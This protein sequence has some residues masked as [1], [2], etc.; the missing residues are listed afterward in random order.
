MIWAAGWAVAAALAAAHLLRRG[1]WQVWQGHVPVHT[2]LSLSRGMELCVRAW[3][4]GAP[5]GEVRLVARMGGT[6]IASIGY[7]DYAAMPA[8]APPRAH[9]AGRRARREDRADRWARARGW[10]EGGGFA[11]GPDRTE[12]EGEGHG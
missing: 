9:V 7:E 11:S 4:S 3:S 5:P 2:G 10:V 1:D 12:E 8:G 6:E